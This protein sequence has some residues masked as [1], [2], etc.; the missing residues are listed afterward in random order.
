MKITKVYSD[1]N[2]DSHFEDMEIDLVDNGAI[3]FL[4]GNYDVK[5][6]Q[7]RRVS[8]DYDYDFHCAP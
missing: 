6:L 2:G 5:T 1:Q 3:G 7:F 8:A 4:S